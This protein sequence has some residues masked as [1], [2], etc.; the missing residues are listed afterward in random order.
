MFRTKTVLP[1]PC[2]PQALGFPQPRF[3]Q[4]MKGHDPCPRR[5]A[6]SRTA[7]VEADTTL[8]QVNRPLIAFL[9]AY[10][11]LR[12]VRAARQEKQS[13]AAPAAGA[14][15]A[16]MKG[17]PATKPAN[18]PLIAFLAIEGTPV[19][20]L[21]EIAARFAIGKKRPDEGAEG[22]NEK[23]TQQNAQHQ[24]MARNAA[25]FDYVKMRL[26]FPHKLLSLRIVAA[27]AKQ[28]HRILVKA[29]GGTRCAN[30]EVRKQ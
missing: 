2:F 14:G 9:G 17:S 26:H 18:R 25:A 30:R 24:G 1:N 5:G 19:S 23:R 7:A 10:T 11:A 21:C 15:A 6:A 13:S 29:E 12:Y 28:K 4:S 22:T 27:T 3:G 20:G 16:G 8:F